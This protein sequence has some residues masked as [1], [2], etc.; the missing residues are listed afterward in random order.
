MSPRGHAERR[1]RWIMRWMGALAALVFVVGAR[2]GLAA[3]P[4]PE[5][6]VT[7]RTEHDLDLVRAAGLSFAERREGMGVRVIGPQS[8]LDRLR[9]AGLRVDVLRE[10]HARPASLEPGYHDPSA[11]A[12]ALEAIVAAHPDRITLVDLGLSIE[13]R[14]ILG[15]RI[16]RGGPRVRILGAHHGNELVSQEVV[17][18][19]AVALAE[20]DPPLKMEVWVVPEVN[21]D[22]VEAGTRYDARGVDL[23]RNYGFQWTDTEPYGG[24]KAFSEPETRAIRMLSTWHAPS[25]GLTLHSGASL[26]NYI[27]NYTTA[28]SPDEALVLAMSDR[29]TAL[30]DDPAFRTTNGADWYITHGDTNDWSYGMQ[31]SLDFTVEVSHD[32]APDPAGLAA[33][34]S[35]QLPAMMDFVGREPSVH[36]QIVDADDGLPVEAW[37][38]PAGGQESVSGQDGSFARFFLPGHQT[39]T[40]DAAGYAPQSFPI[41]VT[42]TTSVT[43]DVALEPEGRLESLPDP[44]LLAWSSDSVRID[45]PEE[46][47]DAITLHRPGYDDVTIARSEGGFPVVTSKLA[48]GPWGL[49]TPAGSIG[50]ALFVGE[51]DDRVRVTDVA[52]K[53]NDVALTGEGFGRGSQVFAVVG[54][55]RNLVQLELRSEETARLVLDGSAVAAIPG[56]VDLVVL[57]SGSVLTVLDARGDAI[58]DT[59][60][61]PDTGPSSN[62][63]DGSGNAAGLAPGTGGCGCSTP[64][65]KKGWP[66]MILLLIGRL[67]RDGRRHGRIEEAAA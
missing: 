51:M 53:G 62:P 16:G 28:D 44:R 18:A 20:K 64:G 37:V 59:G 14:P 48:P 36:G 23:N 47:G 40:F 52:W 27:W 42:E 15:L 12:S 63:D 11:M 55:G 26:M 21:P 33:V 32:D 54:S 25:T 43:L 31:G 2:G 45:F 22:G 46:V 57:S 8:A 10:D 5:A 1:V 6:W 56:D 66:M 49:V 58:V 35:A 50:H 24:E 60:A 67:R 61:P 3:E 9:T 34:V 65:G 19:A 29:Y 13:G 17:L 30:V 39:L 38:L 7:L 41:D 4:L